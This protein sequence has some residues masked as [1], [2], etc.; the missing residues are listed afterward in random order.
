M[1]EVSSKYKHLERDLVSEIKQFA[2][3]EKLC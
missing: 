3:Y 1:L 2:K